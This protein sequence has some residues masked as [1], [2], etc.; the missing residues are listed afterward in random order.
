MDKNEE[1]FRICKKQTYYNVNVFALNIYS[2]LF[3]GEPDNPQPWGGGIFPADP[4]RFLYSQTSCN[5]FKLVMLKLE[6]S[7]HE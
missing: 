3:F 5:S 2:R 6:T 1:Y 4:G 7:T